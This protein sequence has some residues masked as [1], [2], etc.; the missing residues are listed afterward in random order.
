MQ[1]SGRPVPSYNRKRAGLY[2]M[3]AGI[4]CALLIASLAWAAS[5]RARGENVHQ[6]NANCLICHTAARADLAANPV[7][8]RALLRPNLEAVCIGCHGSQGKSHPT[9]MKPKMRVPPTLP[10]SVDGQV[11]CATC[12]FMHGENNQFG[13]FDRLDNRRGQLCLSCHKMSD[14]Q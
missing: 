5:H 1:R 11:T 4:S 3:L 12:H 9:G 6:P 8:A 2:L 10:L 7:R 13:D 14:L